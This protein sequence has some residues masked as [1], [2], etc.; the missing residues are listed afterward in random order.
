VFAFSRQTF[1]QY[2]D[3][4]VATSP[5]LANPVRLT[6]I[7]PQMK[8]LA[9]SAGTRLINYTSDKGDKLQGALYLP[10]N[11]EPGKKYP[12]LVTIYEKRSQNLHGFVNPSETQTPNARM[13]TSRGYAV[14][15]PDITY[16]I[17]DPGMSAVWSVIPAVKAVIA[18]GMIDE[19]NVGLWGHSWGGYQTAFLVTQTNIFKSA[20]AGA[21]LTDMVS[22]YSSIYWNTGGSNQAIFESSQGRFKGNF[23]DNYEAYIRNSPVFHADKVKTPLM[24]LH[25]D[26]DGAVDFN[27]GVIYFNTLRQLQKDVIMLEYVG[28]N[29]GVSRPVNQRDY[30]RRMS[31]YFD[32]YLKGDTAPEWL[33]NGIPRLQITDHLTARKDS[34]IATPRI[35]SQ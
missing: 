15:D 25:N 20:I 13:Y 24:L 22:M 2:P 6:D 27:Q 29:H 33:K 17:N 18:T 1:T 8:D 11:Y 35:I 10:A 7:N 21:A 30:A 28:E 19:K 3:W 9:I 23:I 31:E 12:L 16:K 5:A 26:K 4:W 32:H 14:F 34:T